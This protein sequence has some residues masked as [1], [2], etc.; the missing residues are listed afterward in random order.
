[1]LASEHAEVNDPDAQWRDWVWQMQ[2]RPSAKDPERYI[3]PTDD[4][5]RRSRSP[6]AS[7]SSSR[8]RTTR[9]SWIPTTGLPS[10]AVVPRT[11]ELGRPAGLADPL[12]EVAHYR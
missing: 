2:E 5:R 6:T 7:V 12:D 3:D 1:L 10:E 9:R 11:V 4:E 8:C